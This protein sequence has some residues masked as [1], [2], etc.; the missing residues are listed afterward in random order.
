VEIETEDGRTGLGETFRGATAVETVLHDQVAPWLIG[1][2]AQH[3][4]AVSRH[5]TT[6]YL[7]FNSASA[8]VRGRH[9]YRAGREPR[10]RHQHPAGHQL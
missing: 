7:G 5:L 10:H 2:D 3:I 9:G 8:E 1:R 6:S 4:E